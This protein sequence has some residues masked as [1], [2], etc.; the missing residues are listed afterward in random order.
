MP[1]CGSNMK[2]DD[3]RGSREQEKYEI[4]K[5]TGIMGYLSHIKARFS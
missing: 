5:L 3:A 2:M 1:S 4:D